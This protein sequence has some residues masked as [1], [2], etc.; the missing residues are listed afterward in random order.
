MVFNHPNF[1]ASIFDTVGLVSDQLV[2]AVKNTTISFIIMNNF[3]F[4]SFPKH[5]SMKNKRPTKIP[6]PESVGEI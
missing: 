5:V 3:Q 6:S 4:S 1:Y 2:F